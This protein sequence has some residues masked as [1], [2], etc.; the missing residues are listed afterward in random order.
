MEDPSAYKGYFHSDSDRL[1][2]V[3]YAGAYTNQICSADPF[4][5]VALGAPV[6]GWYYNYTISTCSERVGLSVSMTFYAGGLTMTS[7]AE[8][9]WKVAPALGG[10]GSV[11]TGYETPLGSFAT[12]WTNSSCGLSVTFTTPSSTTGDLSI[13]LA[14]GSQKLVLQGPEGS[15]Q[16]QLDGLSVATVAGLTGGNYEITIT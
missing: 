4:T 12:S 9:T 5:G 15:K 16:V 7:A 14:A 1:N 8:R 10:L 6:A 2:R 11:Q 3:W 13:P